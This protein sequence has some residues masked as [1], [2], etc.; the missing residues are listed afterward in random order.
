MPTKLDLGKSCG[1][2]VGSAAVSIIEAGEGS[3]ALADLVKSVEELRK[4]G[5]SK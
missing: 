5:G 3:A 1:I 2:D 4:S